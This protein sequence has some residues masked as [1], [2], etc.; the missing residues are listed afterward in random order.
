M[1]PIHGQHLVARSAVVLTVLQLSSRHV[2]RDCATMQTLENWRN[3]EE[4][5]SLE[6]DV[7]QEQSYMRHRHPS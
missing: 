7:G 5:K 1:F 2:P 4:Q 6:T 3:T